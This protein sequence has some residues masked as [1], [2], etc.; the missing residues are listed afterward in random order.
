MGM[1]KLKKSCLVV[2][3]IYSSEEKSHWGN[4]LLKTLLKFSVLVSQSFSCWRMIARFCFSLG[5]LER[6]SLSLVLRVA[7]VLHKCG[8]AGIDLENLHFLL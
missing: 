1:H 2:L 6:V 8:M 5:S 4:I 7:E 3:N